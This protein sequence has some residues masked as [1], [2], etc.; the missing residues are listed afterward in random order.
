MLNG[1]TGEIEE[2]QRINS[3]TRLERRLVKRLSSL[4]VIG[5][6]GKG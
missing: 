1:V 5:Q 2:V 6:V 4:T 3:S